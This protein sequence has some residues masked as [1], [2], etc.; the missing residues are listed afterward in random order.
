SW[1]WLPSNIILNALDL[2]S[3]RTTETA[4]ESASATPTQS[5]CCLLIVSPSPLQPLFA[6][7]SRPHRSPLTLSGF[8]HPWNNQRSVVAS[9][10]QPSRTPFLLCL[11]RTPQPPHPPRLP[12]DRHLPLPLPLPLQVLP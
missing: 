5:T 7:P 3:Y 9:R 11:L 1:W 8:P 6:W 12:L 10:L 4:R 2:D